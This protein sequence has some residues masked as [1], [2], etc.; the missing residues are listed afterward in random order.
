MAYQSFPIGIDDFEKLIS[1]GCYYVDKTLLIRELLEKRGEVNLFVRPR[2]FGKT[3]NLSMLRYF[4]EDTGSEAKNACRRQLFTGLQI[5][6][7]G[8]SFLSHMNAYPVIQLSLKSARQPEWELSYGA[9]KAALEDEFQRHL[10]ILPGISV[11]ADRD[12]FRRL[13]ERCGTDQDYYSAL[14]FLSR[15]LQNHYGKPAIILIDEYDV[16]LE[17]A[18]FGGFYQKMAD[19]IR[20]LF[21]SALKSNPA[22]HFA[23]ITGCLRITKESIFTGL[24]NLKVNS[25]LSENYGEYFGFTPSEVDRLAEDYDR[26]AALPVIRDWY[27]GY[28]FGNREVYNPWSVLNYMDALSSNPQALPAPYWSNTS[29]NQIVREL[30]EQADLNVR[31]EIELLITGSTIEKPVHEEI[32]YE[33]IH[34]SQDNLWNFLLFTGYLKQVSRRLDWDTQ[35]CRLAIPNREVLHIF[36]STVTGWFSSHLKKQDLSPL[37]HALE[38][39]DTRRISAELSRL[40]Q[41]SISFYD[42]AENY[43]HGFLAGVLQNMPG[44]RILSNREA[45]EGRPDLILKTPGLKGRAILIEIKIAGSYREM[46]ARCDAALLQIQKQRYADTLHREGY[47]EVLSYGICFYRK[48]CE[49]KMLS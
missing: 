17:N 3:L 14:F 11:E 25:I 19:F 44:Y 4:F 32:T 21:E 48:D 22:L 10:D 23:V 26:I 37:F 5:M 12:R 7:A 18:Y 27:D 24:N 34:D 46:D 40:L 1:N 6:N 28:L 39:S 30:I 13:V 42:Y 15:M 9:L 20:S 41:E 45:G 33:D 38:T 47:E 31:E 36:R 49:V 2:R 43:Y 29:S 8:G 16:P 35:Y